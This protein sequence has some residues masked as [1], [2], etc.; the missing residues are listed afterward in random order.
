MNTIENYFAQPNTPSAGSPV[1]VTMLR[2]LKHY[3]TLTFEEAR[4][5]AQSLLHKA[6]KARI[7]RAPVVLSAE[8]KKKKQESFAALNAARRAA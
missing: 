3:P 8:A 5:E 2:V 6:A 1:G 4:A 7:Y